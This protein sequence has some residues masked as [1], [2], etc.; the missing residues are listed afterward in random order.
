ML[1]V[2]FISGFLWVFLGNTNTTEPTPTPTIIPDGVTLIANGT[3][4]S[5]TGN[6]KVFFF[7][8]PY[9]PACEATEPSIDRF[10]N[11]FSGVA[12]ISYRIVLTHSS[13][14]IKTYGEEN[15]TI[16][17]KYF[18]CVQ[19][20]GLNKLQSFKT[21]FYDNL[22]DDGNDYIPFNQTQLDGF[23]D[24]VGVNKNELQSCLT[25]AEPRISADIQDAMKYGGGT[26]GT[27]TM[28]LDCQ[29][30]THSVNADIAF[31]HFYPNTQPCYITTIA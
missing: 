2:M 14:M 9:C 19:D 29:Y 6:P 25:T 26:Y 22:K 11:N 10:V 31:C 23:A 28:V 13:S 16:A 8:D 4:C 17:H 30:L 12:N 20:Q 15:V 21:L 1:V 5:G 18:L 7:T 24:Q 27:P 3:S